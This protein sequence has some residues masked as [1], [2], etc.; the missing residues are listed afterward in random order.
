MHHHQLDLSLYVITDRLLSRGR[1]CTEVVE[2]AIDGG[3]TCIQLREKDLTTREF[4]SLAEKLREITRK[5]GTTFI[6]NDRLD[7]ALSVGADGVHLGQDDLPLSAARRI[8]PPGMLLG[9]SARNLREALQAQNLG[10]SYLGVGAVFPTGTKRDAGEPI[11]LQ[12]LAEI[13][14][15]V[16]IPVVGIGGINAA[17]AGQVIRAGAAGVAV[18]SYIVGA[19]DVAAAAREI[20]REVEDARLSLRQ[21]GD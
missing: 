4:F 16:E 1:S 9:V 15:G 7:I 3:A 18:I 14:R 11:G 8:I 2:K 19:P 12:S 10:A 5:R 21:K 17:N 13:C 20:A 6:V